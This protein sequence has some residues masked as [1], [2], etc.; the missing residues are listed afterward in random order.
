MDQKI[1]ISDLDKEKYQFKAGVS[2]YGL[3]ARI[4]PAE[5]PEGMPIIQHNAGL[6]PVQ[7]LVWDSGHFQGLPGLPCKSC[8]AWASCKVAGPSLIV[9]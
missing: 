5:T 6:A 3:Q 2:D 9:S 8:W 7:Q 1:H 4:W